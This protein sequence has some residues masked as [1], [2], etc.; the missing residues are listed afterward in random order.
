MQQ[1]VAVVP[2]AWRMLHVVVL[3]GKGAATLG[4]GGDRRSTPCLAIPL[5]SFRFVSCLL[6]HFLVHLQHITKG[7]KNKATSNGPRGKQEQQH[8]EKY[9]RNCLKPI[10]FRIKEKKK[11][12]IYA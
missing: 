6:W 2:F 4:H 8:G 7:A 10:D 12:P 3:P 5:A 9:Q 1:G 11:L